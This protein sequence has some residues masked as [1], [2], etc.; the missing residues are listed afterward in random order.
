MSTDVLEG[1]N[2][3]FRR[4]A[5]RCSFVEITCCGLFTVHEWLKVR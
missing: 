5:A 3:R 1:D 4:V 2:A